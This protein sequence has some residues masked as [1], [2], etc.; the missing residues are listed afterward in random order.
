VNYVVENS[1][2]LYESNFAKLT[3]LLPDLPHRRGRYIAVA[4]G[5]AP[6]Y[7]EILERN[8]YTTTVQIHQSLAA[9]RPWVRDLGM[10]VRI[11]HDARVAEV[12]SYQG[13]QPLQPFYS[14]PNPRMLQP[15]EKRRVNQFLGEWLS[16]CFAHRLSL[17]L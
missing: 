12:I 1:L 2:G 7:V 6:I 13:V 10:K 9:G 11:Y 5:L 17:A 15:Y 8:P 3:A 16:Y 4:A 14:Y